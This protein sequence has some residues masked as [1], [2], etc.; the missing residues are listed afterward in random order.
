MLMCHKSIRDKAEGEAKE[1]AL[2]RFSCDSYFKP[3]AYMLQISY[4]DET[5]LK[6]NS[7]MTLRHSRKRDKIYLKKLFYL[8][9]FLNLLHVYRVYLGWKFRQRPV[10]AVDWHC[11]KA[12]EW[13]QSSS[14]FLWHPTFYQPA[15]YT[16]VIF[17]F[18]KCQ[19][20]VTSVIKSPHLF[21]FGIAAM[22]DKTFRISFGREKMRRTLSSVCE[23]SDND[24][25]NCAM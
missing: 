13:K 11:R 6:L 18:H 2:E 16:I 23:C 20:T 12:I 22:I 15:I 1:S 9:N 8:R 5:F 4:H 24:A 7:V 3:T 19:L 21:L 25:F 17:R 14:L 10:Q